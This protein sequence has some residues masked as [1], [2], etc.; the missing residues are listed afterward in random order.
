M[1]NSFADE[2]T[3]RRSDWPDTARALTSDL[4]RL[5]PNLRAEGVQIQL[6]KKSNQGRLVRLS[7]LLAA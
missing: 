4:Q 3:K 2:N 5:A 7:L 1:L 6:L